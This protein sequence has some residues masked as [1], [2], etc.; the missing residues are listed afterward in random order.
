[1]T[2]QIHL[3]MHQDHRLWESEIKS[4]RGDIHAWQLECKLAWDQLKA[5]QTAIEKHEETLRQHASAI[6]LDEERMDTHEHAIAEFEA[7]GRG[8]DLPGFVPK[9]QQ[10]ADR[11]TQQR[12]KHDELKRHHHEFIARWGLLVKTLTRLA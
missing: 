11:Q 4:W 6:R 2:A 7:G 8:T 5:L 12:E 1:M 9:H 3:E 10:E